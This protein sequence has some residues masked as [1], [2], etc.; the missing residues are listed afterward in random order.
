MAGKHQLELSRNA[1]NGLYVKGNEENI[2]NAVGSLAND[3]NTRNLSIESFLETYLNVDFKK[4]KILYLNGMK[5]W[6]EFK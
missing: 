4:L 3:L 2:R 1:N 5:I 6:N